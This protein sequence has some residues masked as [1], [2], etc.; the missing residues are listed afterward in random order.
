MGALIFAFIKAVGAFILL[1]LFV[2]GIA[3][4]SWKIVYY[5]CNCRK[6]PIGKTAIV[7]CAVM[8]VISASVINFM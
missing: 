8:W 6:N 5:G 2:I 4:A 3:C 1:A 7:V